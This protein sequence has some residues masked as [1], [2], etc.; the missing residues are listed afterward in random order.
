M[1]E[2]RPLGFKEEISSNYYIT[3]DNYLCSYDKKYSFRYGFI[4][5]KLSYNLLLCRGVS[6]Y[7]IIFGNSEPYI[8]KHIG[9]YNNHV[10]YTYHGYQ[11]KLYKIVGSY[12][13]LFTKMVFKMMFL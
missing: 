6:Y 3:T 9:Y 13:M 10:T 8:I 11:D 12:N 1:I 2:E 5:N 4:I 7:I